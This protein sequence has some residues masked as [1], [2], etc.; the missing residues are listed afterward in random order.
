MPWLSIAMWLISFLVSKSSGA[1]TAKAAM[2]ATGAGLATYYLADPANSEN[3][4][5]LQTSDKVDSGSPTETT[6]PSV[7]KTST[8]SWGQTAVSTVG[9]VLKSWGPTGTIG[10]VAGTTALTSSSVPSWLKWVGAGALA[11]IILR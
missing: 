1:S 11:L 5:G 2:I 7:P 4:L 10:V 6:Q 9:D 3:I 8:G